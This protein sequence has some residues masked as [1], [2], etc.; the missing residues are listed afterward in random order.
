MAVADKEKVYFLWGE[1]EEDDITKLP[2]D[3]E[4]RVAED[5]RVYFLK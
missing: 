4:A 5:S 2:K 3:W 1:T